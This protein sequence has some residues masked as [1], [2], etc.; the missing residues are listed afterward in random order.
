MIRTIERNS[1]AETEQEEM[2]KMIQDFERS[3]YQR[4]ELKKIEEK[5]RQQINTERNTSES[6]TLT[7]PLFYFEDIYSFKKIL[8]D[9]QDDL[10]QIIGNTKIIM[11]IKKNPSTVRNKVLSFEN[12]QLE[13]QKCGASNCLQCP[14]VNTGATATINGLQVKTAKSLNCKSRNVIYLWQCQICENDNSYFGRTIQKSHE[15]TNT[16]RR[17]FSEEKWEDSA[18]S[19]HSHNNHEEQFNLENFKITLVKK[20]SPQRI[21]RE[22]FKYIDRY[23][24]RTRGINRYKN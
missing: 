5:A 22:E 10:Q 12:K 9:H 24:T 1:I 19:M 4:E 2:E 21:R 8:S 6:D 14:L 11:A 15:R 7:F 3:G 20:C 13:N 17:C 16:H 18:L 23:R